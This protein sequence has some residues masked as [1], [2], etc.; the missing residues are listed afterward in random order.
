MSRFQ[1]INNFFQIR[2][3]KRKRSHSLSKSP[4]KKAKT[5]VEGLEMVEQSA[6]VLE[7]IK[8]EA[9]D[10]GDSHLDFNQNLQTNFCVI[11]SRKRKSDGQEL[12]T[13]AA[14]RKKTAI[15]IV[16]ILQ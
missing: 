1:I 13:K 15:G 8:K 10:Q 16:L 9:D 11:A 5:S 4:S 12:T 3:L 7:A 6:D 2:K 14:K